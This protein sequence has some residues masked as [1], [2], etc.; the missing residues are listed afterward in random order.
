MITV[1]IDEVTLLS[2]LMARVETW[3]SSP[4]EQ[5]LFEDYYKQLIDSGCFEG[6]EFDPMIIVDNDYINNTTIINK[7]DFNQY[8]I[9]DE[10]DDRILVANKEDDLYLIN[11]F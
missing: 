1:K 5:Q 3:I 11:V 6:D 8:N 2:M 9:E 10:E 7:E 4:E